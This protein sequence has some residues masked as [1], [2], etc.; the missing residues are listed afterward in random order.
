[1]TNT[2]AFLF[3]TARNAARDLIR[4]RGTGVMEDSLV[5]VDFEAVEENGAAV[6]E[7][8]SRAEE[9]EIL[10][11]AIQA[12]PERCR[13]IMTL[14]KIH[15]LSNREIAERLGL[16]INTVNAQIVTGLVRCRRFLKQRGV[17]RGGR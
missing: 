3:T 14:Q 8:V 6:T 1:M 7:T 2:R 9:I 17:I 16:S 11:Q 5:E 15:S 13:A 12:L 10:H 4:R